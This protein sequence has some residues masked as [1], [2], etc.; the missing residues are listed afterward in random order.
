MDP[1]QVSGPYVTISNA[2]IKRD[3]FLVKLIYWVLCNFSVLHF[4][5]RTKKWKMLILLLFLPVIQR[6]L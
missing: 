1:V 3:C 6:L 5:R 4:L 2:S